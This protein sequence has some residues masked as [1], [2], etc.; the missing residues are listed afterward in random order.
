[1]SCEIPC[2]PN[3]RASSSQRSWEVTH[4]IWRLRMPLVERH[5]PLLFSALWF[6]LV[7]FPFVDSDFPRFVS[8]RVVTESMPERIDPVLSGKS[9]AILTPLPGD[10]R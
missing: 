5:N 7:G 3:P 1:V 10:S 9:C 6:V 2:E 4:P 8:S